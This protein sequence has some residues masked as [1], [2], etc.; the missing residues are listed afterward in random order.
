MATLKIKS[1]ALMRNCPKTDCV[2]TFSLK[3]AFITNVTFT[4]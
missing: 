4:M 2:A 1:L 3:S